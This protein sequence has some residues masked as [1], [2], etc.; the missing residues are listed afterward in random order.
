MRYI[1][2]LLLAI[3]AA[4]LLGC[5]QNS[6]SSPELKSKMTTA[7]EK[8]S[9]AVDATAEAAKAQRD[10]YA[11][12][13][14]KQLDALNAKYEELKGRVAKAEDQAKV[15]LE[16]KLEEARVKRDAAAKQLD[17]LKVAG[18]DRW[19]KVKVGVGNAFDEL[20]KAFD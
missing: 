16:K 1:G 20:K 6:S 5:R 2:I 7:K 13:M 9:D 18:A 15:G 14:H 19:E 8:I 10:E 17:E 11:R 4:L 3:S 12:D